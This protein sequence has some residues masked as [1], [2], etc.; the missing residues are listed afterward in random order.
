[1]VRGA[2]TCT[3]ETR[4][5]N[6]RFREQQPADDR[7]LQSFTSEGTQALG[8]NNRV[9]IKGHT[10]TGCRGLRGY[11]IAKRGKCRK[12]FAKRK[13]LAKDYNDDMQ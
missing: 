9:R 1:V 5:T 8:R 2:R 12:I 6:V 3:R 11:V 10:H 7:C 4:N 13:I